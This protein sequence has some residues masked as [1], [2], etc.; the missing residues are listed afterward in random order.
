MR[1]WKGGRGEEV[2]SSLEVS[3]CSKNSLKTWKAFGRERRE[4][5]YL[6]YKTARFPLMGSKSKIIR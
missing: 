4:R 2:C 1:K 5:D 3:F 6:I